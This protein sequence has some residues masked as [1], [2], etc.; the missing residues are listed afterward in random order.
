MKITLNNKHKPEVQRGQIWRHGDSYYLVV[1]FSASNHFVNLENGLT[2]AFSINEIEFV[3]Y[4]LKF[5][6]Y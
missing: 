5:E 2:D 3:G 1:H 4:G 6:R